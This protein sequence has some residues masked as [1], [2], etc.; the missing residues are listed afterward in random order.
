[1]K[2]A[3]KILS[4]YNNLKDIRTYIEKSTLD[5]FVVIGQ[6]NQHM[7]NLLDTK[8]NKVNFSLDSLL[9]NKLNHPELEDEDYKKIDKLLSSPS[10]VS[11]SKK[12]NLSILVFNYEKKNYLMV[13]KTVNNKEENYLTSFRLFS[14][15]EFNKY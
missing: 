8:S 9:K 12:D 5:E 13:I 10:K 6:L 14:D 2:N 11:Y 7:M 1:M 4:K 3:D 15:K